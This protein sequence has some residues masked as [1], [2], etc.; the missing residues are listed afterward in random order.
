MIITITSLRLR[1]LW[2]FFRLSWFGFKIYQKAKGQKG[3]LLMHNTGF[4]Y[5]HYTLS[6]WENEEAMRAFA[7]HGSI[8]TDAM[9]ESRK[10][11]TEIKTYTYQ[12]EQVP[13]WKT[14]KRLVAEKGKVLSFK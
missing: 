5:M 2:Q 12:A 1:S 8:H 14:A 7:Y 11:S 10:L 9:K 13:D 3:N 4:G 6:A